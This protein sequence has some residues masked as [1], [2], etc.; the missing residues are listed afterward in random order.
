[1]QTGFGRGDSQDNSNSYIRLHRRRQNLSNGCDDIPCLASKCSDLERNLC[2]FLKCSCE[3]Q[4]TAYV[5]YRETS[6]A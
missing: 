1:M 4:G 5:I 3:K 6:G 2:C